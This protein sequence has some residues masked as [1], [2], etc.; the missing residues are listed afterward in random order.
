MRASAKSPAGWL[1]KLW[2]LGLAVIFAVGLQP[3]AHADIF[4]PATS[5]GSTLEIPVS[6]S[7][8][9]VVVPSG[10]DGAAI[11]W[12]DCV[13]PGANGGTGQLG[14]GSDTGLGGGAGLLAR[15]WGPVA[16]NAGDHILVRKPAA[17]SELS[18]YVKD[19]TGTVILLCPPGHPGT[20][21]TGNQGLGGK[22]ADSAICDICYDAGDGGPGNNGAGTGGG[23][24]GT[25]LGPGKTGGGT[26][27]GGS[28]YVGGGGAAVGGGASDDGQTGGAYTPTR[29]HG[30][31][32][33]DGI[34]GGSPSASG[35]V[36]GS[37]A[38]QDSGAGGG[39]GFD[40]T[41][42]DCNPVTVACLHYA[43][44]GGWGAVWPMW[45]AHLG[46]GAAGGGAG[47]HGSCNNGIWQGGLGGSSFGKGAGG[48]GGGNACG[49]GGLGG[50][51]TDSE[52]VFGYEPIPG[53]GTKIVLFVNP[54]VT[55]WTVP[56]DWG[57]PYVFAGLGGTANGFATGANPGGGTAG[58]DYNE[59]DSANAPVAVV[60]GD[61]ITL[62]I[63]DYGEEALSFIKK[64]AAT[65]LANDYGRKGAANS[66]GVPGTAGV[67]L[68]VHHI[69]GSGGDASGTG[70][71]KG[72]GGGGGSANPAGDGKKGGTPT[73]QA[74]AGGGAAA[75]G[76]VGAN[77]AGT[78]AGAGGLGP[79]GD[80][81]G[82]ARTDATL[83]QGRGVN[84]SG[85]GGAKQALVIGGFAGVSVTPGMDM[86]TL[87]L[88]DMTTHLTT[89]GPSAGGGGGPGPNNSVKSI[90]GLGGDCGGGPGGTGTNNQTSVAGTAMRGAKACMWAIYTPSGDAPAESS[91]G[92]SIHLMRRA[93]IIEIK[94]LPPIAFAAANDNRYAMNGT[95]Q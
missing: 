57:A 1:I 33:P 75:G 19:N 28:S 4:G 26:N 34:S 12:I 69:G 82:T 70:T 43:S 3:A 66:G 29:G 47:G 13:G 35:S 77:A 65:I 79:H 51:G 8:Q 89:I 52:I 53:D 30:G 7:E 76:A 56:S 36:P 92:A 93:E 95:G 59:T 16:V 86:A 18:A 25:L 87:T 81:G 38:L 73:G 54:S 63:S 39:P 45:A 22:V 32:G 40:D 9:E 31:T 62:K 42:T 11:H 5:Y 46:P 58:G 17:N 24:P 74:S 94:D 88:L 37:D 23:A 68:T 15:K 49:V 44:A 6:N 67:G 55:T 21:G 91:G 27:E 61:T 64:G 48:G 90:G 80:A 85:G 71:S 14:I 41:N 60:A 20:H 2:G 83:L 72:A 10:V 50:A 84:G 78:T